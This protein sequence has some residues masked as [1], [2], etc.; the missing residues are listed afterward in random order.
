M[1]DKF[2]WLVSIYILS[3]LTSAC[4]A[5]AT[6]PP[7]PMPSNDLALIELTK[8]P[9]TQLA[10]EQNELGIILGQTTE[11]QVIAKSGDPGPK[12][13]SH[14][15]FTGMSY[16][17][18]YNIPTRST[19]GFTVVLKDSIAIEMKHSYSETVETVISDYGIPDFVKFVYIHWIKVDGAQAPPPLPY[20][21][22]VYL[23]RGVYFDFGCKNEGISTVDGYVCK[24]ATAT[25]RSIVKTYFVP[26]DISEWLK[27]SDSLV[28]FWIKSWNNYE[29]EQFLF[30]SGG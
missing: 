12:N 16:L 25:D 1:I 5:L 6:P 17:S 18:Y 11:A 8:T 15:E 30:Q 4:S 28:P 19:K 29:P 24:R 14:N 3:L 23:A 26:K 9:R 20:Y 2:P 21:S 7:R 22:L 27:S 13:K 10:A